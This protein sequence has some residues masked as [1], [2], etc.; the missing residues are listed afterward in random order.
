MN[1]CDRGQSVRLGQL[2]TVD[3]LLLGLLLLINSKDGDQDHALGGKSVACLSW[4]VGRA[5]FLIRIL[6]IDVDTLA[7]Q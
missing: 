3:E 6:L 5:L 1:G 4:E 7:L 2:N